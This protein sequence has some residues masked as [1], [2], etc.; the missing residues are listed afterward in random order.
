MYGIRKDGVAVKLP[1][2]VYTTKEQAI[3]FAKAN[4]F[5]A[6]MFNGNYV[7]AGSNPFTKQHGKLRVLETVPENA[8]LFT[9]SDP[10]IR[11]VPFY[12]R[13]LFGINSKN[14]KYTRLHVPEFNTASGN[15]FKIFLRGE[16]IVFLAVHSPSH[17][18][19]GDVRNDAITL[20]AETHGLGKS[21]GLVITP[22][23]TGYFNLKT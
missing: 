17:L 21:V 1:L 2:A 22:Q 16:D 5:L 7:F 23:S 20:A 3:E 8:Q 18:S 4:H 11:D 10:A 19:I 9:D 12:L 15:S 6:V 14:E 13:G